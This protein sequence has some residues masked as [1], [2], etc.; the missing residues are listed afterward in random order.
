[1]A[2]WKHLGKAAA[3]AIHEEVMAAHGGMV[4]LRDEGLLE[5]ALA[6]PQATMFGQAMMADPVEIAAAYLFYLCKN[7]PFLDG[8][9][10][11]ALATA[12]VFLVENKVFGHEANSPL[13]VDPWEGL[14]LDV[15]SGQLTREETTSRLR[16]LVEV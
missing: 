3:L 6:A 12:L 10:R 7:H 9:K 13:P 4:G 14:V 8:N 15:A 2:E 11:T 1:M 5:S 16:E